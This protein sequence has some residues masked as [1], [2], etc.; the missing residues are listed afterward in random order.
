[1]SK[2]SLDAALQ[3][4]KEQASPPIEALVLENMSHHLLCAGRFPEALA[5]SEQASTIFTKYKVGVS[6]G[7]AKYSAG[8]ALLQMGQ[9]ERACASYEQGL[10][11]FNDQAPREAALGCLYLTIASSDRDTELAQALFARGESLLPQPGLYGEALLIAIARRALELTELSQLDPREATAGR[12]AI[13]TAIS[14]LK[15]RREY[16]HSLDLRLFTDFIESALSAQ[17]GP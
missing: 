4:A 8:H 7:T 16:R 10:A 14:E 13:A 5:V 11:F 2:Q 3:L 6:A 12:E 9:V 15:Q 17:Q 1:M